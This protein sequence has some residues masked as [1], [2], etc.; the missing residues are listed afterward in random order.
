[1]SF[2][3]L[4]HRWDKNSKSRKSRLLGLRWGERGGGM[5][6]LKNKTSE[7]F[8][9]FFTWQEIFK[10]LETSLHF[11]MMKLGS[12]L[13][14]NRSNF[15]RLRRAERENSFSLIVFSVWDSKSMEIVKSTISGISLVYTTPKSIKQFS[16]FTA[17][18]GNL[19]Y[20]GYTIAQTHVS[21]PARRRRRNY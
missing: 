11:K 19:V 5:G 12:N 2:W 6:L 1:M 13:V 17:T 3:P 9:D 18:I 4:E 15:R 16:R 14:Q 20:E 10:I 21:H 7:I 8:V